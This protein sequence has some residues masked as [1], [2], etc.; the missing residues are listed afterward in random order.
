MAAAPHP[1]SGTAAGRPPSA[2]LLAVTFLLPMA[3]GTVAFLLPMRLAAGLASPS[4]LAWL[5]P[6]FALYFV[7]RFVAA[8]LVAM[9]ADRHGSPRILTGLTL[10]GLASVGLALLHPSPAMIAAVQITLGLCAGASRPLLLAAAATARTKS[11]ADMLAPSLST[12]QAALVFGPWA[13]GAA[14]ALGGVHGALW[15]AAGLLALS[16]ACLLPLRAAAHPKP[17]TRNSLAE[18]RN[19][20]RQPG[21]A[22]LL[23]GVVCRSAATGVWVAFGPAIAANLLPGQPLATALLFS[24]PAL[25]AALGMVL[26]AKAFRPSKGLII[27]GMLLS[28]AGMAGAS[29]AGGPPWLA[30]GALFMGLGTALSMPPSTALAA[31]TLPQ[32]KAK[33]L[34]LFQLAAGLGF[35]TGPLLG[36]ALVG[37]TFDP[38]LTLALAGGLTMAGV[39]PLALRNG[40]ALTAVSAAGLALCVTVLVVLAPANGSRRDEPA[41]VRRTAQLMGTVVHFTLRT[42]DARM[43]DRA[44][45]AA[46]ARM[47]ALARDLDMRQPHGAIGRVNLAAGHRAVRVGPE[48]FGLLERALS[49]ARNSDGAFDPTIGALTRNPLYYALPASATSGLRSLVD[50]RQVE[51]SS[52]E[53]TVLL[54]HEGMALDLGG[55]A[56]GAIVDAAVTTLREH[57]VRAGVVEAGGDLF[58]F[59]PREWRSGLEHPRSDA[60]LGTVSVR[61][62]GLCGSGDYRKGMTLPSGERVNHIVD[63]RGEELTPAGSVAAVYV[64]ADSAELADG[65]ATALAV[66]GPRS[67]KPWLAEHYPKAGALWVDEAGG[68]VSAGPFPAM[69]RPEKNPRGEGRAGSAP[70]GQREEMR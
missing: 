7:V 42:G 29:L 59:G 54:K 32:G 21:V 27:T 8:P 62:Q 57:G 52:E 44:A 48:A 3:A 43:A 60:L 15:A 53:R 31:Q 22:R 16:A 69:A 58:A 12:Q 41:V 49:L 28:G 14:L 66:M 19:L 1:A 9:A 65:L 38:R 25:T 68:T 39:L 61:N 56:K 70:K 5:G 2:A 37:L 63:T 64:L 13:A 35:A 40:R 10:L 47:H 45:D 34:A 17:G 55:I 30:A 51:L 67:G 36:G 50:F 4:A 26:S 23:T 24:L 18:I 33:A 6:V 46:L 20:A 11:G